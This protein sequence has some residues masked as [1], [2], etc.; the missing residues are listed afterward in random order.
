MNPPRNPDGTLGNFG[1]WP[2]P[3]RRPVH[4]RR[5]PIAAAVALVAASVVVLAGLASAHHI[6]V[7]RAC[8]SVTVESFSDGTM[9]VVAQTGGVFTVGQTAPPGNPGLLTKPA[10]PD[11]SGSVTVT[12]TTDSS[13][14]TVTWGEAVDC[15]PV[16]TTAPPTTAPPTT[17]PPTTAPPTTA[18]PTTAP[19]T[20]A[21]PTTAPPTTVDECAK[22]PEGPIP[23]ECLPPTIPTTVP[24][25]TVP[26]PPPST[27][28]CAPDEV[29][30][31]DT[32][33]GVHCTPS[34][35]PPVSVTAPPAIDHD[36]AITATPA[37]TG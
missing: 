24:A 14:Q 7:T 20:T 30:V 16:T 33:G 6:D 35:I 12:W 21:P 31:A 29:Q 15:T 28:V 22:T 10:T 9:S 13:H 8:N 37:F 32:A 11:Q 27:T 26:P 3:P 4:R 17:A 36:V 2:D 18:P 1:R 34:L 25:P 19:P 5:G 23:P